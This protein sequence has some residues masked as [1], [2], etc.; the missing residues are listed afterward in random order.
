MSLVAEFTIPTESLPGGDILQAQPNLR[1]ELE[2]VVPTQESALPFFWVWGADLDEFLTEFKSEA[3]IQAIRVLDQV[4][5]GAL[6]RAKWAPDTPM[7]TA[8]DQL[9][10][11]ILEAVGSGDEWWFQIRASERHQFTEFQ[12]IFTD[13]GIPVRLDRL[14]NFAE[15]VGDGQHSLTEKQRKTLIEAF[16]QGYFEEPRE[17]SQENL[18]K[19][20]GVSGRAIAKR[21]RLG[22]QNLIASTLITSAPK[23]DGE[24][25]S[26][27]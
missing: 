7:I 20:F 26:T 10:A 22:T 23:S 13:R 12:Q 5:E 8:L 2:R 1:I 9:D 6:L 17:S 18:G 3:E 21:L 24:G 14:Y 16:Q 15:M 25:E 19:H 27:R 11:T 4:E